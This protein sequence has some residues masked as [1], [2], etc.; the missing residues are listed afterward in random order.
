[1]R[2]YHRW[3]LRRRR[4]SGPAS[5]SAAPVPASTVPAGLVPAGPVLG[6]VTEIRVHGVGGSSPAY[7]LGVPDPVQ[8]AGDRFAGF[9]RT[10]DAEGRHR[11]AFSWG[12]LT[13][14]SGTRVL[15][16]FL[17]P[18]LLAN[19]AGWMCSDLL[20]TR[21]VRFALHR[22]VLRIAALAVTLNFVLLIAWIPIDYLGYQCG[23][24][25]KCSET[26]WLQP[27]QLMS[28]L[29]ARR[30]ALAAVAPL[31]AIAVLWFLVS[32]SVR[33]FEAVPPVQK[34]GLPLEEPGKGA[35]AA[36][37]SRGSRDGLANRHFWHG[38]RPAV[39]LGAAHT[40]AALAGLAALLTW[41]TYRLAVAAGRPEPLGPPLLAACA[42]VLLAAVAALAAETDSRWPDVVALTA[43]WVAAL[44]LTPAAFALAAFQPCD[45]PDGCGGPDATGGPVVL[46][47]PPGL[48]QAVFSVY[49]GV[50]AVLGVV[51]LTILIGHA[52]RERDRVRVLARRR[53]IGRA[54]LFGAAA[55][56]ALWLAYR[57]DA[58]AGRL[59]LAF[60]LL[61]VFVLISTRT[62]AT[63]GRFRWAAPFAVLVLAV[64]TLN[65]FLIGT[66]IRVAD[67]VGEVRYP[68]FQYDRTTEPVIMVFSVI[69]PVTPYLIV[70][71]VLVLVLFGLC[72]LGAFLVARHGRQAREVRREYIARE[73]AEGR[74]ERLPEW[75]ASTVTDEAI[76]DQDAEDRLGVRRWAGTV[77]GWRRLGRATLD[78]DLLISGMAVVN[79]FL[80]VSLFLHIRVKGGS[81][82]LPAWLIGLGS[83]VAALL[84]LLLV[85][86]LSQG[87]NDPKK[88]QVIGV[89][90]D[91]GT[92]WP[93]AFHPFAP[94]SYAERA[95]P[96]LQRR[97]WWLHD[98]G[99]SVVLTAHSQGTLL[100]AAAL[101][102][103][104]C[105]PDG[106]RV[107]L[108][109]FGSPLV[110]LY[111]WAFPAYVGH[112]LLDG[113]R[114][115]SWRNL[116]YDTDYI[117][118]PV[119]VRDCDVRRP[120]P[121][122]SR[123][124]YGEPVPRVGSH[125]GYWEDPALWDA[126]AG[127]VA[128]LRRT[129]G[130]GHDPDRKGA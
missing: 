51:L 34:D 40:A 29:P 2:W 122:A 84:P 41:L 130:G 36:G 9:Y 69:R 42:L 43:R 8:V 128:R 74:P 6:G 70:T 28:D 4:A 49:A 100:A 96:D 83:T 97:I 39:R 114:V 89:L 21:P 27:F 1:M 56:G 94:P 14:R 7:L 103:R 15:W 50:V 72:E 30:M 92:F 67:L 66:L 54:V 47:E 33:Q 126:V 45:D 105:R 88:R 127:A 58:F 64:A 86:L 90:W 5:A 108:V 101:A 48:G 68:D 91:V 26:W 95:V 52:R 63:T 32:R 118:G 119:R 111:Q 19:L 44:A 77:S 121:P 10:G 125:T 129:A 25:Q 85:M 20:R 22:A 109:T 87:W 106:D 55:A 80:L 35:A 65:T 107:A 17:L 11:E 75:V 81:D 3:L 59:A 113:L 79:V 117:G 76:S 123:F 98:N 73:R 18:F 120:D 13:S 62:R 31:V 46:G 53:S 99:G 16:L 61:T 116:Y 37:G 115:D 24:D 60:L 78:A 104:D 38:R 112:D 124:R 102:Q 12:G 57:W 23:A 82:D 93:R 71:P 110:K